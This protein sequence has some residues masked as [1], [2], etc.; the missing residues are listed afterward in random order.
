MQLLVV[1]FTISS[2]IGKE[3]TVTPS[4]MLQVKGELGCM[5]AASEE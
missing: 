4:M 5:T 1:Y 3:Q 2:V